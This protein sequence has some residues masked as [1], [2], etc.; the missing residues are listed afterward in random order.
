M[1]IEPTTAFSL[2]DLAVF[3][4]AHLREM[5]GNVSGAVAPAVAGRAFTSDQAGDMGTLAPLAARIERSLAPD[6]CATFAQARQRV[7]PGSEREAAHRAVLDMLFWELTYWKTPDEYERLTAGEQVHLGA[8][9]V[10]R[11]D[12][13]VVLDA[14]AGTGRVSLPL[15]RRARTVYAMDAAPPLLQLLE[16]KVAAANL[17]NVEVMRGVFRRVPLPDDSVDVVISCSAFG[18]RESRGGERGLDEL[19]RVTRHGGRILILWPEDPAWFAR[20]G[21]WY[22]T[23]PGHL[24][25]TFPCLE[26]AYAVATRFY[27]PAAL[28]HLENTHQPELPFRV[29]GVKPP[30][31]FCCLTV[32]K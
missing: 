23:L 4:E 30:R 13:A 32:R 6:D 16:R 29:L 8:L 9:D 2:A 20:H 25:V 14:G 28:H 3:D 31:D 5:I 12:D 18:V 7:I 17:R 21:F 10:A 15:A 22:A 19:Q 24:T 1:S 11:V 27:G 26:D